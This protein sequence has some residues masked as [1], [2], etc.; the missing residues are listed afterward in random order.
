MGNQNITTEKF[1]GSI[2]L[3]ENHFCRGNNWI[4]FYGLLSWK[5]IARKVL[6]RNLED[7]ISRLKFNIVI[8]K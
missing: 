2:D 6:M 4:V 1:D 8:L 5:G 3:I 7:A